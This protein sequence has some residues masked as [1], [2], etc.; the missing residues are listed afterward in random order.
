MLEKDGTKF[1]KPEPGLEFDDIL[2]YFMKTHLAEPGHFGKMVA[3]TALAGKFDLI[4][5][6]NLVLGIYLFFSNE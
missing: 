5:A 1:G 4:T 3:D 6:L 2:I